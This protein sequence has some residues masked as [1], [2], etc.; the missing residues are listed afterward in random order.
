MLTKT[1]DLRQTP[2]SIQELLAL[3]RQAT[4]IVP[5]RHRTWDSLSDKE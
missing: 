3:V 5:I 1:I 2:L 4:L